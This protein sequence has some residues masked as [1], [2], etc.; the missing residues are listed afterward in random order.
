MPEST[1]SR[2]SKGVA[3]KSNTPSLSRSAKD[4]GAMKP[5]ASLLAITARM[6]ARVPARTL[7]AGTAQREPGKVSPPVP[8]TIHSSPIRDHRRG[9]Q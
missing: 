8:K 7:S 9:E 6:P 3:I 4:G 1:T 2:P 5:L